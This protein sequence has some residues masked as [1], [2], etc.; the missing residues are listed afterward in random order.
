MKSKSGKKISFKGQASAAAEE[1]AARTSGYGYLNLPKGL[2]V[3][4]PEPGKSITLDFF[5]YEVTTKNHPDKSEAT[6]RAV[7]GAWWYKRPFKI[8]RNIGS[9]KT[10]EVCLGSINKP[11]PVCEYKLKRA[12]EGADQDELKSMK[13]SDRDLYLVNPKDSPKHEEG[14]LYVLDISE[15]LF[16]NFLDAEM[17][18]DVPDDFF[19]PEEGVSLKVRF[20]ATTMG[21]GKPFAEADKI[22]V[23]DRKKQYKEAFY[24]TAADLDSLLHIMTYDELRDKFFE[25]DKEETDEEEETP[26]KKKTSKKPVD[27][28][29]DEEEEAPRKKKKVIVE[30]E[31]EDSDDED[32]EEEDAPP[33]RKKKSTPVKEVSKKKKPALVEEDED[34]DE[35][36]EPDYT[37]DDISKMKEAQLTKIVKA[38][39]DQIDPDDYEDDIKAYRRAVASAMGIKIP[40]T[41]PTPEPIAKKDRCPA[42]NGTGKNAKG[43]VC[44]TCMGTGKKQAEED[45]EEGDDLPFKKG[46]KTAPT[47]KGSTS[48][49][50]PSDH[51]F[52]KDVDKF[53]ECDACDL[54]DECMAAKKK[55]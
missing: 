21:S 52:G 36:D 28:D 53:D 18:E 24:M 10:S 8:H 33:I 41:V 37:W 23:I 25:V 55:K 34:E 39:F 2:G 48:G 35:D 31:D 44:K 7:K 14:K 26:K 54:W 6:G 15:Y 27:E 50:C 45:D 43:G 47:K 40:K 12:K 42:C 49:E 22:T 38:D 46:K 9:D 13:A 29:E 4:S 19:D 20:K 17:K 30:E 5:P 51:V 3:F 11:C 32:D 1:R 16:Q